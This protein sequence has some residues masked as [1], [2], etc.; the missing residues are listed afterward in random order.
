MLLMLAKLV[1]SFLFLS[2]GVHLLREAKMKMQKGKPKEPV[3][4]KAPERWVE[5]PELLG[6]FFSFLG[7]IGTIQ[8]LWE[9][10]TTCLAGNKP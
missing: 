9:I 2:A 3:W 6:L 7:S 4:W 5:D 10:A 1:V 8:I